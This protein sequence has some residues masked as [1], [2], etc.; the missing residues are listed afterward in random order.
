MEP[1]Q[2]TDA[3]SPPPPALQGGG[4]KALFVGM[5]PRLLQTVPSCMVYWLAVEYT[6]RA[7]SQF[8]SEEGSD[9]AAAAAAAGGAL[10]LTPA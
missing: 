6:R 8:S 4:P 3:P 9:G 2:R 5:S 7:L 1:L 10:A